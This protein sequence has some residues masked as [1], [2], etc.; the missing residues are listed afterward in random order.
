M[1]A[2]HLDRYR[3]IAGVLADEGLHATIDTLGLGRLAPRRASAGPGPD[4]LTTEQHI[5]RAIERLGVTFIKGGQS[6][7]T[8]TDMV[9]PALSHE[10]RKLQDEVTP[11][12]FDTVR[13]VVEHDLEQS[14]KTA[15]ASFEA[16]PFASASIGQVHRA[17]LPDGTVVAVKVQRPGVREQVEVDLDITLT[18]AQWVADHVSDLPWMDI[19]GIATEFA[20][21]VRGELDYVREARNAERLWRAFKD[22]ETVAFPRV[23][24][25][26]TTSRVLTLEYFDGVRMNRIDELDA[27]GCDR[28]V[29]ALRGI[30][31]YLKQIFELGFFHADPHPGNFLALEGDRVAFTD[32]GRVGTMSRES[33]DRFMDLLWAAVNK[34]DE[35]ATD[36]FMALASSPHIDEMALQKEVSH[37]IGK[38]HGRELGL[39]NPTELFGEVLG[40]VRNHRLGVSNDFALALATLGVLEGVGTM[41]DPAFDFAAAATPFVEHAM[42]ERTRPAE[43]LDRVARGWRRSGRFFE[44]LPS[45]IDRI[46]RRASRGEIRVAIVPRDYH[47]F[48]DQLAE[49][50]NRLAF[51]LV[52]SALVIGASSLLS[53]TIVPDWLRVVGQIGLVA[54]FVVTVWFLISIMTAHWRGRRRQ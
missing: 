51:A 24:W 10:L 27:V 25:T 40:L 5:R 31:S 53:A 43:V 52:V 39:I 35:L 34:D 20:D 3:H 41:L 54:A 50:V 30:D 16:E 22:D 9:P 1:P 32:F 48:I 29:L 8:R 38:Y 21:A 28:A 36:T 6:L 19:V 15:F 23:Y 11:E 17:E 13:A 2:K 7:A 18:Q 44:T 14:I 46:L 37:L 49:L 12:P 47:G 45:S 4:T 26:H 33:R 42:V